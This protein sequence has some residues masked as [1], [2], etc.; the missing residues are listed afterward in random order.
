MMHAVL[1]RA[2]FP[3]VVRLCIDHGLENVRRQV[4]A[5]LAR[6]PDTERTILARILARML[7]SIDIAMAEH[8]GRKAA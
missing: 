7:C 3:D 1:R 6:V 2:H 8:A 5:V 4:S